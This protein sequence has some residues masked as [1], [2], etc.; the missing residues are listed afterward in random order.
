[1]KKILG[2]I[3]VMLVTVLLTACNGD[4]DHEIVG[5]WQW[6]GM[7]DV[8]LV[9]NADGTGYEQWDGNR[10]T[11]EW[12]VDGDYVIVTFEGGHVEFASVDGDVLSI[13]EEGFQEDIFYRAD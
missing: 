6:R 12:A 5:T 7:V 11:L 8:S 1:M 3:S 10:E 13:W 2:L 4:S 9:F